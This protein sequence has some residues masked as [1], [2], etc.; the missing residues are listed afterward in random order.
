MG[1]CDIILE[2]QGSA[3]LIPV[4]DSVS[5]HFIVLVKNSVKIF[6]LLEQ[7]EVQMEDRSVTGMT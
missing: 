4:I 1:L 2:Q 3:I 6:D 7:G 5:F